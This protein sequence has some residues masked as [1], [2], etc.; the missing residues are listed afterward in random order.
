MHIIRSSRKHLYPLKFLS[1]TL[2]ISLSPWSYSSLIMR[3][4]LLHVST[5][6]LLPGKYY[7]IALSPF[8]LQRSYFNI[9][10][11]MSDIGVLQYNEFPDE[12]FG[13]LPYYYARNCK[14]YFKLPGKIQIMH[15][16]ICRLSIKLRTP[17]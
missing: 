8:S 6:M 16:S 9:T 1:Y 4:S 2:K 3:T 12:S 11:Q 17:V 7:N 13:I 15:Y 14:F 5:L 10:Q